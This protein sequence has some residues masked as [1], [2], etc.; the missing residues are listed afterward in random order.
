MAAPAHAAAE[1]H[2][3]GARGGSLL[4]GSESMFPKVGGLNMTFP[5]V[6]G[7]VIVITC[8][9]HQPA[10]VRAI[11][12]PPKP[13]IVRVA[14]GGLRFLQRSRSTHGRVM[15]CHEPPVSGDCDP[16]PATSCQ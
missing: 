15:V 9:N 10:N 7:W 13:V 16:A 2:Q 8:Y 12:S 4:S 11:Q 3:R 6:S 1:G 5:P 14:F